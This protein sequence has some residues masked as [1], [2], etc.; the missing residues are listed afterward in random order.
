MKFEALIFDM[1]GLLLETE[2]IA[3]KAFE[4][5][6]ATFGQPMKKEVYLCCI[7]TNEKR[8]KK[9]L[10]EGYGKDFPIEEIIKLWN[11]K[12]HERA[13]EQPVPLKTGVTTLLNLLKENGIL[14]AIATST[15]YDLAVKKLNNAEILNYFKEIVSGDMVHQSKPHPEIYLTAAAKI[16]MNPDKCIALEDSETGVRA[17]IAAGMKVFQ[18]PDLIQ[19]SAEIRQ[20]GHT[21]VAS[22]EEVIPFL[23]LKT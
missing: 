4:E 23:D 7:G 9:I 1:D 21:I 8:S 10:M 18:V 14:A 22:L 17:A 6:C 20:L 15:A 3:I 13:V 5:A 2:A 16:G 19:P 11:E 12:Y